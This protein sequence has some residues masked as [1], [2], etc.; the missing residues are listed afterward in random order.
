M[1]QYSPSIVLGAVPNDP[2]RS[3]LKFFLIVLWLTS[4]KELA[5]N[6]KDS[7][8]KDF[9]FFQLSFWFVA[10]LTLVYAESAP[11]QNCALFS[12]P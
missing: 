8:V 11:S 5:L 2:A 1:V 9:F 6:V 3:F 12:N 10:H 4:L 7:F